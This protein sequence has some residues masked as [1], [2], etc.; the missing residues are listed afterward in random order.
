[1]TT[2]APTLRAAERRAEWDV[3]LQR[4][5]GDPAGVE[6][7][8][9][10]IAD[11]RRGTVVGYEALAR[12]APPA[13]S[14]DRW[15]AEAENRGVADALSARILERALR[16]RRSLPPNTLLSV[17][18]APKDVAGPA[19]RETLIG[20]PSLAGIVV[21]VTEHAPIGDFAELDRLLAP[22]RPAGAIVAVDDAG[23]GYAGL[24]HILSSVRRS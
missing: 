21:E 23:A 15:L 1:M 22:F 12:C 4:V 16:H 9:Q 19:V 5:L 20:A 8:F 17:N 10:P 11:L 3:A 6:T 14:P 13:A 18:V 24:T 7:V 2:A